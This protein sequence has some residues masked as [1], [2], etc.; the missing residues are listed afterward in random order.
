MS[1]SL[2][3]SAVWEKWRQFEIAENSP[4][5]FLDLLQTG[6]TSTPPLMASLK[7]AFADQDIKNVIYFSHTLSSSCRSLGASQLASQLKDIEW[8]A[9]ATPPTIQNELLPL[10]QKM[11]EA[12]VEE[13][14]REIA[15]IKH[16]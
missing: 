8:A 5:F 1:T 15:R 2:I 16:A 3:D 7:Q 12:F 10:S 4:G 14:K 11:F 13:L 6:L 9:R